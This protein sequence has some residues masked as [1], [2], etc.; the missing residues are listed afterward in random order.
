MEFTVR[1][2]EDVNAFVEKESKELGISK[3]SFM[4]FELRRMT[5]HKKESHKEAGN[6]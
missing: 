2:P 4:L 5:A 1:L 6:E 3:S